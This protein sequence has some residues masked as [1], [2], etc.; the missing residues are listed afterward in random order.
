MKQFLR[1]FYEGMGNIEY[2]TS[3]AP[4]VD[5]TSANDGLSADLA[6]GKIAQLGQTVG[7]AGNPAALT[8][9][10]EIPGAHSVIFGSAG[11]NAVT[12]N[13]DQGIDSTNTNGAIIQSES[14]GQNFHILYDDANHLEYLFGAL[15]FIVDLLKGQ[16]TSNFPFVPSGL[17]SSIRKPPGAAV[18]FVAT[19]YT[20]LI[21]TT[22]GNVSISV[23]PVALA[24]QLG[25]IK[26]ISADVN[27][28]TVTP[29]SGTIQ[30]IGAPAAS[31]VFNVQGENVSFQSDGI[32]IY[33]L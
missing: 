28:V 26:K 2:G 4:A 22:A 21:D 9:D 18:V 23:D 31:Y 12:V 20:L 8:E 19:D 10:R 32:N 3:G 14:L 33:I 11:S 29:T 13:K 30:G 25:N 16:L 17:G 15:I 5:I 7:R 6:T 1:L 24:G 27:T